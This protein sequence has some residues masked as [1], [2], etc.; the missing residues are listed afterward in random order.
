MRNT[1]QQTAKRQLHFQWMRTNWS[2]KS[3]RVCDYTLALTTLAR[4]S[5]YN[6][7]FWHTVS[8]IVT[9]ELRA[10]RVGSIC[11]AWV[12]RQRSLQ[13]LSSQQCI[14]C[15]FETHWMR[16]LSPLFHSISFETHSQ[17]LNFSFH[18]FVFLYSWPLVLLRSKMQLH[19][20][21]ALLHAALFCWQA[22]GVATSLLWRRE[23]LR[24]VPVDG[25]RQVAGD[26][27]IIII[28]VKKIL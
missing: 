9:T 27:F 15:Q 13:A 10:K 22:I 21:R 6:V 7:N 5:A 26:V 12:R 1:R 14:Q 2:S 25:V 11:S 18:L 4:Q 8:N 28:F 24:C 19:A 3:R 16:F 23:H 17:S 20:T